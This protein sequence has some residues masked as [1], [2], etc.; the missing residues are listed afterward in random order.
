M[1][2]IGQGVK[3][4]QCP[5]FGV[6]LSPPCTVPRPSSRLEETKAQSSPRAGRMRVVSTKS[7]KTLEA[8]LPLRSTCAAPGQGLGT[9]ASQLRVIL[10]P[11][12]LLLGRSV[13]SDS[14]PPRGLEPAKLLCPW[15]PLGKN[16]GVGG[17]SFPRGSFQ[18]RYQTHV[19]CLAGRFFTT[20]PPGKPKT[21]AINQPRKEKAREQSGHKRIIKTGLR[22]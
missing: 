18:P 21:L 4:L 9:C 13:M 5:V 20:K 16:T 22:G 6:T 3:R 11:W 15:D 19:S 10:R 8:F 1:P 17:H 14:V 7:R 12:R 2:L